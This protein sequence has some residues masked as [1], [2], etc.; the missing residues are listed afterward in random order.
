MTD[1]PDIPD[2][3][4]E[5]QTPKARKP[6]PPPHM[7]G[8]AVLQIAIDAAGGRKALGLTLDPTVTEQ[9]VGQWWD[10]GWVPPER[11]RE[12]A[13]KYGVEIRPLL[14]PDL[15]RVIYPD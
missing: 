2:Q 1:T 10:R 15:V 14:K 9:A 5:D 4:D 8:R 6:K 7:E 11:A 13:E 12:L 3:L